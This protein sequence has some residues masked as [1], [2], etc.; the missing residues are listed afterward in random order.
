MYSLLYPFAVNPFISSYLC[1]LLSVSPSVAPFPSYSTS[2]SFALH[3]A[4]N[5]MFSVGIYFVVL[6]SAPSISVSTSPTFSPS[7]ASL[8]YHP[9]NVYP[10][11]VGLG[12]STFPGFHCAYNFTINKLQVIEIAVLSA[13][14]GGARL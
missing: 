8:V 6:P 13:G 7:H 3:F 14:H 5:I 10:S 11:L 4:Y 2:Y 9:S 1:L 12:N